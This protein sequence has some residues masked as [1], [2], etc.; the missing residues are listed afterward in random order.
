M[1]IS[2]VSLIIF[3]ICIV[4]FIVRPV[5]QWVVAV[6][7]VLA[8]LFFDVLP[9]SKAF[10]SYSSSTIVLVVGMMIVGKA[11]F[12]T[13]MAPT[14]GK[15][16]LKLANNDE[17]KIVIYGTL[18]TGV[19][20][21]FLS[22]I[23]TLSVM[24]SMMKGICRSDSRVK[25]K[26]VVMPVASG[27][28]LG[29]MATL[30]GSTP[31]ITAQGILEKFTDGSLS[32]DLFTFSVPGFLIIFA[33]AIYNGFVGYPIGKKVW[34]QREDEQADD[35][36]TE[37]K[38]ESAPV[39]GKI[40]VMSAIFVIMILLFFF[41]KQI[42]I[43]IPS[44]N[45]AVVAV[46]AAMLCVWTG[47]VRPK[48]AIADV[49]WN[50]VVWLGACLGMAEGINV[51]GGGEILARLIGSLL[52]DSFSPFSLFATFVVITVVLSHFLANS[53]VV[54]LI[55]PII[56]PLVSS[57][58]YNIYPFAIG[59]A[60]ASQIAIAT[61]ISNA[62]IGMSMVANYRFEDYIKYSSFLVLISTI[63]LLLTVPALYPLV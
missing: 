22:N 44:F 56:L 32:F 33:A 55:L 38:M 36:F 1:E 12:D 15:A 26:N 63:I 47:C 59:V 27:A 29:G 37:K 41:S 40:G 60:M 49:D 52:K 2:V 39:Q 4:L 8:M 34:G 46:F 7:G 25:F 35:V 58:G 30:I 43:L 28:V 21:A 31:Q 24:I 19:M 18:I 57:L 20:S 11:V 3:G 17:R 54:A 62:T 53:T 16:I 5:P 42:K 6:T 23:A 14:V 50:L 45:N 51:S 9:F 61:P 13:G 48:E 10:G